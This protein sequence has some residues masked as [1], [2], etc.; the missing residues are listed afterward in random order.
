MA[1]VVG[2]NFCL[3]LQ[4]RQNKIFASCINIIYLTWVDLILQLVPLSFQT[5]QEVGK[6]LEIVPNAVVQKLVH[7]RVTS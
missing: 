6:Q 3:L 2:D 7:H 4:G 5:S 1:H